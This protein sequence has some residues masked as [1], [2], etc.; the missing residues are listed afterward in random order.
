L[1]VA[2]DVEDTARIHAQSLIVKALC[3]M[4]PGVPSN[5][6]DLDAAT[7]EL[8]RDICQTHIEVASEELDAELP[9][10]CYQAI[11]ERLPDLRP[12][13]FHGVAMP[14]HPTHHEF[15]PNMAN[16]LFEGHLARQHLRSRRVLFAT[17]CIRMVWVYFVLE[18]FQRFSDTLA[19]GNQNSRFLIASHNPVF[20]GGS[21]L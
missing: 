15:V 7:A 6:I 5:T 17:F 16:A 9:N 13:D 11:P 3:F 19:R 8:N 12:L 20:V 2:A 18:H 4:Y 1:H 14:M 21:R 10:L